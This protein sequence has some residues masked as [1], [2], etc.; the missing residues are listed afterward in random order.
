MIMISNG[1]GSFLQAQSAKIREMIEKGLLGVVVCLPAPAIASGDAG[2]AE[3][4]VSKPIPIG[5]FSIRVEEMWPH[6]RRAELGLMLLRAFQGQGYGTEMIEWGLDWAFRFGNL[7]RVSLTCVG[8]N[9]G[10][11]KL[12]ER[13]GFVLEGTLREAIWIDGRYYPEYIMSILEH[14]WRERRDQKEAVIGAHRPT[15]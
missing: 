9:E 6:H 10:A 8:H 14:E 15:E 1:V 13:L 12:Y 2:A 7:H 3:G 4:S 5:V 11:K